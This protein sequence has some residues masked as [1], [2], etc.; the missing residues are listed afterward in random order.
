MGGVPW[1]GTHTHVPTF[2]S[3]AKR[4]LH[5]ARKVSAPVRLPSPPMTQRLVMPRFTRLRA[6]FRRPSRVRKSWHRALPMTVP[7]CGT[8]KWVLGHPPPPS[9]PVSVCPSLP[10]NPGSGFGL[11]SGLTPVPWRRVTPYPPTPAIGALS[12][13]G[14]AAAHQLQHHGDAF[15]RGLL[16][17]VPTV[18]QPL[19]A[20]GGGDT[21]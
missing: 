12:W 13:L 21:T 6:A 20:L 17:V 3:S 8:P 14:S 15:P 5:S 19:I 16:D 7:P 2:T 4:L 10:P 18:H 11:F 9:T 1:R